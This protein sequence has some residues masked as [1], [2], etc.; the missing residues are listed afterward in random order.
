MFMPGGIPPLI[1]ISVFVAVVLI[2]LVSCFCLD[3][4]APGFAVSGNL[5]L[6]CLDKLGKDLDRA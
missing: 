1:V 6:A 2:T 4:V 5:T 3:E